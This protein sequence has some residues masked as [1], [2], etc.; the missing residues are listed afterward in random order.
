MLNMH[1]KCLKYSVEWWLEENIH[2][3]ENCSERFI[4][5]LD[6][7]KYYSERKTWSLECIAVDLARLAEMWK[8]IFFFNC[9]TVILCMQPG[10]SNNNKTSYIS[11]LTS[12]QNARMWLTSIWLLSSMHYVKWQ[13]SFGCNKSSFI[14]GNQSKWPI[15][16]YIKITW[17]II[18]LRA[19]W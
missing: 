19:A 1:L 16:T 5:G 2:V 7:S 4:W 6:N 15:I 18:N 14:P 13:T 17:G 12:K 3:S 11:F 9:S 10:E 8:A